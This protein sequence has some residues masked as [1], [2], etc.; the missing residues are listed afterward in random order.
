MREIILVSLGLVYLL[1]STCFF[2]IWL[3]FLKRDNRLC[4]QEKRLSWVVL[5]VATIFWIVVVPIAYFE[6]LLAKRNNCI[7]FEHRDDSERDF[8]L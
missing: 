2:T 4:L 7:L 8:N 6:V 1:M 3:E 5:V